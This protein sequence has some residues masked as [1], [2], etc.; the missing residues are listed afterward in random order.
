MSTI[1]NPALAAVTKTAGEHYGERLDDFFEADARA[2]EALEAV[3]EFACYGRFHHKPDV[4]AFAVL[5]N[6]AYEA[7][8]RRRAARNR[9]AL[10]LWTLMEGGIG[11][12]ERQD[13]LRADALEYEL[14]T[15]GLYSDSHFFLPPRPGA[16]LSDAD[17]SPGE[18]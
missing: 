6:A 9:L 17:I 15:A 11:D 12:A 5:N 14:E 7:E 16:S 4:V 10:A 1:H 3:A 13:D 2:E 8:V 18:Q